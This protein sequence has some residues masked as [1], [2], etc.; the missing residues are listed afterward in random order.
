M[1]LKR[2]ALTL[3]TVLEKVFTQDV[4]FKILLGTSERITIDE[5]TFSHFR[6]NIQPDNENEIKV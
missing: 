1:F 6:P 3:K 5:Y 2:I 4:T